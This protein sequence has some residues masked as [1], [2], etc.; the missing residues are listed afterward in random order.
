MAKFRAEVC[1]VT[2]PTLNRRVL[3]LIVVGSLLTILSTEFLL[4]LWA[5][6]QAAEGEHSA[7]AGA[8]IGG[9]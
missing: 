4:K 8:I 7:I 5:S 2:R 9:L 1:P 3:E 6:R